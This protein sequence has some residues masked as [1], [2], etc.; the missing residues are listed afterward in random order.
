MITTEQVKALRDKTGISVMQCKEALLKSGGDME[1]AIAVLKEHGALMSEKKKDR[2]L[3]SGTVGFYVHGAGDV[4][5]MALLLCET[6]FVAKNE[7]FK[8]L[9]NDIAMQIAAVGVTTKD[10]LLASEF[11]KDS[12][13]KVSDLLKEAVQ[14]FGENT[15][16]GEFS[17][18]S[19]SG[20]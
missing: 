20:R 10:D 8:K 19:V 15:D 9:A 1:K 3:G 17:R 18:F 11:F 13:K 7:D 2:A 4:G 6:D 12:S 14:K 5:A 16:I